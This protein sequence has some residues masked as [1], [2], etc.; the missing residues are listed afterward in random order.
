MFNVKM[1]F[2]NIKTQCRRGVNFK[3]SSKFN[4]M[5]NGLVHKHMWP[6]DE[7]DRVVNLGERNKDSNFILRMM[8][9]SATT[10]PLINGL[11]L[12][13]S[14]TWLY[15]KFI[16][17]WMWDDFSLVAMWPSLR[18]CHFEICQLIPSH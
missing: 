16:W 10:A 8:Q 11:G 9:D 12:P 5:W 14:P 13:M 6:V 4:D 7:L 17:Q 18:L 15:Y 3:I 2:I 1:T